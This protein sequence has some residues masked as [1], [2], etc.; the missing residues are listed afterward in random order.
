MNKP[1]DTGEFSCYLVTFSLVKSL[2]QKRP[3]D[4]AMPVIAIGIKGVTIK[5]PMPRAQEVMKVL[6][7]ASSLGSCLGI[8]G[9]FICDT[10]E[11]R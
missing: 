8:G 11:H 7:K 3:C 10:R 6:V 5:P 2:A 9:R 4:I 1:P